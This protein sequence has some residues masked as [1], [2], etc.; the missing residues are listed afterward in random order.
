MPR[1]DMKA[2]MCSIILAA[3]LVQQ[4]VP[5]LETVIQRAT[6]Y[7]AK[8]ES[9]LGNLIGTEEYLQTWTGNRVR[10]IQRRTSSDVLLI[11][12]GHEW[13]ALRKVNRVE[14]NK[15]KETANSFEESFGDSA[16]DNS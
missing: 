5:T 4:P 2:L 15:V 10:K 7:V 3:L 13:S 1:I 12:V 8:Y 16:A 6:A 14:G 11:E 9:E